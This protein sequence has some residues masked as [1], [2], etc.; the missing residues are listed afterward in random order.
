MENSTQP[1]ERSSDST[2]EDAKTEPKRRKVSA[3]INRTLEDWFRRRQ[4][5]E[6][7]SFFAETEED[8]DD[9]ETPEHKKK[10]SKIRTALRSFFG[11]QVSKEDVQPTE[12]SEKSESTATT[13]AVSS[14]EN[15]QP[16][17][18]IEA[19]IDPVVASQYE[20]RLR[21]ERTPNEPTVEQQ[22][23]EPVESEAAP[24]APTP[25]SPAAERPMQFVD[26]PTDV[27]LRHTQSET[28]ILDRSRP[29]VA[30]EQLKKAETM[31]R[32]RNRKRRKEIRRT[33]RRVEEIE[34]IQK[35]TDKA[36]NKQTK[37]QLE[38][39]Q[40]MEQIERALQERAEEQ[41]ITQQK[42]EALPK[43]PERVIE[44]K[45]IER[46][47]ESVKEILQKR[48]PERVAAQPAAQELARAR[49]E[50]MQPQA[51]MEQVEKAAEENI[52]IEG[53]FERRHEV[54]DEDSALHQTGSGGSAQKPV[55]PF[56]GAAAPFLNVTA[57]PTQKII[58]TKDNMMQYVAPEYKQ[59]V[60]NGFWAAMVLL[61]FMLLMFFIR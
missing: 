61:V 35:D 48:Q 56:A 12:E 2:P 49:Y 44:T 40:R 13:E 1:P 53:L 9:E 55:R 39:M 16:V 28:V 24:E 14:A 31:D 32:L 11:T 7:H 15:T 22:P 33:N 36:A 23:S 20:S 25:P 5:P 8:E 38:M 42:I 34:K 46:P 43:A 3:A 47:A 41:N 30:P 18:T 57:A 58:Q 37:A 4:L 51:V 60:R 52:A 10:T 26:I 45:V 54:K 17:T 21:D 50:S 6:N 19:P 29:G 27:P 59:A